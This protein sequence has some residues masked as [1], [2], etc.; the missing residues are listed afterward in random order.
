MSNL[1]DFRAAKLTT[2]GETKLG[3]N[4]VQVGTKSL[5]IDTSINHP[6]TS[7]DD[8]DELTIVSRKINIIPKNI[9]GSKG[10]ILI[11]LSNGK[12]YMTNVPVI[13]GGFTNGYLWATSDGTLKIINDNPEN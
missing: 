3:N 5:S 4:V 9:A 13:G 10:E 7:S 11:G 2:T 6:T 1:D 12:I 8:A